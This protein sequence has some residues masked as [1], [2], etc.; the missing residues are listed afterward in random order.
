MALVENYAKRTAVEIRCG[1]LD[2]LDVHSLH[3][4]RIVFSGLATETFG[5]LGRV[6]YLSKSVFKTF[7][8]TY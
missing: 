7:P 6:I 5:I 2:Q 3:D 8:T 1:P 4:C